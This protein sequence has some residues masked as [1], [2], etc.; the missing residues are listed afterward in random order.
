MNKLESSANKTNDSALEDLVKSLMYTIKSNSPRIDPWG[1]PYVRMLE[2][3]L[4]PS[5]DTY[6]NL[7]K[8]H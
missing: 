3:Y 1:M 6:R 5:I 7:S 2:F 8:N 4:I